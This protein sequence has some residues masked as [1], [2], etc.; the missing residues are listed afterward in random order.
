MTSLARVGEKIRETFRTLREQYVE[1][2]EQ[3]GTTATMLTDRVMKWVVL[4][5]TIPTLLLLILMIVFPASTG[6]EL[7]VTILRQS[8]R[9]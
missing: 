4:V 8:R 2:T 5:A 1:G 9:L 7:Q 3:K 6:S